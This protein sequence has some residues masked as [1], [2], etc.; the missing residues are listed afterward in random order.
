MKLES[1][2]KY[3]HLFGIYG[4]NNILPHQIEGGFFSPVAGHGSHT[5]I[6]KHTRHI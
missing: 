4:I 6:F 2:A 1:Q 3:N 5:T